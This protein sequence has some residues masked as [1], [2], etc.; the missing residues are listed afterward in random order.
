MKT[1]T[2][3]DLMM[4]GLGITAA[5]GACLNTRCSWYH[6]NRIEINREHR[7]LTW[8]TKTWKTGWPDPNGVYC[9]WL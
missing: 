5:E 7:S 8:S 1:G 2:Q 3:Q 6:P 4:P 9:K